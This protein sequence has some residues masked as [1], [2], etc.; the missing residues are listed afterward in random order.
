M[1]KIENIIFNHY[2]Y[3]ESYRA[4]HDTQMDMYELM[5]IYHADQK[6][7]WNTMVDTNPS[8]LR[9]KAKI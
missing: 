9:V 7:M 3:V 4:L 5:E 1:I 6:T 2:N 8:T